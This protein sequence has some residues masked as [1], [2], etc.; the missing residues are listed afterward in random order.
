MSTPLLIILIVVASVV[1]LALAA[2][3]MFRFAAPLLVKTSIGR[4]I[5]GRLAKVGMRAARRKAEREGT[6]T[7]AS[8]ARLSDAEL[9]LR[10]SGSDEARQLEAMMAK[11]P[12]A[13]RA[14]M[15]RMMDNID[16]GE[17]AGN[18]DTDGDGGIVLNR[19]AK[20]TL[21]R[22]G[23]TPVGVATGRTLTPAQ[24][25]A[26]QKQRAARKRARKR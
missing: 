18:I 7:D 9:M 3:L 22:M 19:E 6:L 25:K 21:E 5:L 2:I 20:R 24:R 23:G 14:Q 10:E 11:M 8:G 13:Q 1:V 26:K 15:R 16:L 17:M 12:A 4:R